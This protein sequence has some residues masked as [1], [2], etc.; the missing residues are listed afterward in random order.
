MF[1]ILGMPPSARKLPLRGDKKPPPNSTASDDKTDTPIASLISM[2]DLLLQFTKLMDNKFAD[3]IK[4]LDK[5]VDSKVHEWVD[6]TFQL[7]KIERDSKL[8]DTIDATASKVAESVKNK[9]NLLHSKVN[10]TMEL[11]LAV[12]HSAVLSKVDT[13]LNQVV[14]ENQFRC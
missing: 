9:F 5:D 4:S 7:L 3:C 10:S 12:L 6:S 11:K 1:A 2:D 13:T 14:N 8:E